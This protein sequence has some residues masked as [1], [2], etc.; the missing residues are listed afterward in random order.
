MNE[1]EMLIQNV[2]NAM[3]LTKKMKPLESEIGNLE[4]KLETQIP[5]KFFIFCILFLINIVCTLEQL[6]VYGS[7]NLNSA[8]LSVIFGFILY[9][10][11]IKTIMDKSIAQKSLP[12][13][14]RKLSKIK[15]Y[16][17]LSWLPGEYRTSVCINAINRYVSAGRAETLKEALI[18]LD[19][20][21]HL[22]QMENVA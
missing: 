15:N 20:D 10:T 8:A 13:I 18:L 21:S 12:V 3:C 1:K 9:I 5:K 7:L 14:N 6:S 19:M 2:N 16:D 11:G 17:T 22:E 4:F